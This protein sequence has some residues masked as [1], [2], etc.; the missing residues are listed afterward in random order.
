MSK[1]PKEIRDLE[2]ALVKRA[3]FG[4]TDD[5]TSLGC[6]PNALDM[7]WY[8]EIPKNNFRSDNSSGAENLEEEV[9]QDS[10]AKKLEINSQTGQEILSES[11]LKLYGV[12]II[13][14]K[15]KKELEEELTAIQSE[16]Y[17]E[18]ET[19]GGDIVPV[20][21]LSTS[22]DDS[23]VDETV[24]DAHNISRPSSFSVSFRL[25]ERVENIDALDL[26]AATYKK[27]NKSEDNSK[28]SSNK[29]ERESHHRRIDLTKVLLDGYPA[30][31]S[32]QDIDL[33]ISAKYAETETG[34]F[35]TISVQNISHAKDIQEAEALSLFQTRCFIELKVPLLPYHSDKVFMNSDDR[36]LAMLYR[37]YKIYA[38]GH[39]C[40]TIVSKGEA[41][42]LVKD[43]IEATFFP[44]VNV[45]PNTPDIGKEYEIPMDA[46]VIGKN[47]DLE[48]NSGSPVPR[49]VEES[50]RKIIRDYK[51]WFESQKSY[52]SAVSDSFQNEAENNRSIIESTIRDMEKGL[53]LVLTKPDV[54]E[55]FKLA[56]YAMYLQRS[57]SVKSPHNDYDKSVSYEPGAGHKWRPFQIAF[58]LMSIP[59]LIDRKKIREKPV[60]IIWMPTGGG[61]TEAY[62][63][64]AAFTILWERNKGRRS[65]IKF[66]SMSVFM[67]Y[68][69]RLL[70]TQQVERAASMICALEYIRNLD[71]DN[72]RTNKPLDLGISAF[73][74]GAFLGSASTPNTNL[75][76]VEQY[77]QKYNNGSQ[78][79][80]VTGFIITSCPWC[81]VS[82]EEGDFA[83]RGYEK[84]K[85]LKTN[86]VK[87]HLACPNTS[88]LF[89][90]SRE[91]ED[92]KSK[93]K[94]GIPVLE[95]DE[96]I[97]NNP[98]SLVIG[99]IDKVAVMA[100]YKTEEWRKLFG[101]KDNGIEVVR[102][103][104]PPALFIQDELHLIANEL[105]SLDGL[106]EV[107]LEELCNYGEGGG[108]PK[109]VGATAT[110]KSYRKQ[111]LN[112]Y[113]RE[114]ARLFPPPYMNIDD[115]FFSRKDETSDGRSFVGISVS[116][117]GSTLD[118]QLKSTAAINH[119][120]GILMRDH[121]IIADPWWTNLMFFS[122]RNSLARLLSHISNGLNNA[123]Y[124][125]Y[126]FSGREGGINNTT[127]Y[128]SNIYELTATA[129][130]NVNTT[131]AQLSNGINPAGSKKDSPR[132]ID[133]CLATS[134]IEVGLDVP[135]LGLMTVIG[136]PK[137]F[138][139][140]IQV[141][142]R[143]GRSSKSP[144]AIF[145]V[146]SP[147]NVRDRSNLETFTTTHERL[148]ASVEPISITPFSGKAL[149]K[150]LAGAFT[151]YAKTVAP[152]MSPKIAL[153]NTGLLYGW[154]KKSALLGKSTNLDI[155]IAQLKKQLEEAISIG[156]IS[157]LDWDSIAD[158]ENG[159]WEILTSMRNV[160]QES[161]IK[162]DTNGRY[163][164]TPSYLSNLS[165]RELD[166]AEEEEGL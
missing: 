35:I 38:V 143:V 79:S 161:Y 112:L 58:L 65:E 39:G 25:E 28:N 11:P 85:D 166:D 134:M 107:A 40:D 46:A 108:C 124:K 132:V 77:N 87:I 109:I 6:Q 110:V 20:P 4:P 96:E 66:R 101:L 43:T 8:A 127:R 53:E 26:Y 125:I 64:L 145:V 111:V 23:E 61:K 136:Q 33:E 139:Q 150:G 15:M 106:Y 122:S 31:I 44:I 164:A 75:K 86:N 123:I 142:G 95:V 45:K 151:L 60:D 63:G 59:S 34:V 117:F 12:G 93:S 128:N 10:K 55:C 62:L 32:I 49:L 67:R 155:A 158:K 153:S 135:R 29:W 36:E 27:D 89:S 121:G 69:L 133:I 57:A 99:T 22:P 129:V 74:V 48:V 163:G 94:W 17:G 56:S 81:R 90:P 80:S 159:G 68:T 1:L 118:G 83:K 70:T 97:F 76:A 157:Q 47:G 30:R 91:T 137:S 98:P 138:N 147:Y 104:L 102:K 105:G 52:Q 160:D 131:L 152:H 2:I 24:H 148:Y 92:G 149:E 37:N 50:L 7:N 156:A 14:P 3:L 13:Y 16:Q 165:L 73:T 82:L 72:K 116:G 114:N 119:S 103:G 146:L 5:I 130:T 144:A 141:T 71:K 140:Y 42:S 41:K 88:C 21:E 54:R 120:S 18:G 100:K 9:P 78:K 19:P 154:V 126:R 113:G 115:N 51:N 162:I 84:V